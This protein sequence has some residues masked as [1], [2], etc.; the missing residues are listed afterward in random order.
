MKNSFAQKLSCVLLKLYKKSEIIGNFSI[1]DHKK[2]LRY[3]E[4]LYRA[5][6]EG[7]KSILIV[8]AHIIKLKIIFDFSDETLINMR[9]DGLSYHGMYLPNEETILIGAKR[10]E[11]LVEGTIIHELKHCVLNHV[12]N[13]NC[14][15]YFHNDINTKRFYELILM[16]YR[17]ENSEE[18]IA[19]VYNNHIYQEFEKQK[20]EL[21]VRVP[22]VLATYRGDNEKVSNIKNTFE[23]LFYFYDE[24]VVPTL[25]AVASILNS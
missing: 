23:D 19:R 2:M 12:F 16:K 21:I 8:A 6:D 7:I 11:K 15:P 22:E 10:R 24:R 14:L 17:N 13:N 1:D 4:N 5:G 20:V 25:K 3:Y 9:L 18:I